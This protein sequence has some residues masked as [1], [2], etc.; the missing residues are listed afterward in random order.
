MG[1][2]GTWKLTGEGCPAERGHRGKW[3]DTLVAYK[4]FMDWSLKL[5]CCM[6]STWQR[7]Q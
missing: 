4:G 7:L 5:G 6:A 3:F 1:V 2:S